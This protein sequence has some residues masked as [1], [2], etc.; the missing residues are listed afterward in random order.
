M[1][2]PDG[3][4]EGASLENLDRR[5]SYLESEFR[6]LRGAGSRVAPRQGTTEIRASGVGGPVVA[7]LRV[8]GV[9]LGLAGGGGELEGGMG[10]KGKEEGAAARVSAR[11]G[12][13]GEAG[14]G[15][16]MSLVLGVVAGVL[17]LLGI[18]YLA[19]PAGFPLPGG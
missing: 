12:R 19:D 10:D 1:T 7:D 5:L 2:E 3:G 6:R 11:R 15:G 16:L 13:A 18:W 8:P 4:H 9:D 14:K 17:L